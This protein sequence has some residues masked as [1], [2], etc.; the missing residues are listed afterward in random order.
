MLLSGAGEKAES[1]RSSV[2]REDYTLARLNPFQTSV[3][4]VSF[5]IANPT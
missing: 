4:Q 1:V 3:R 5:L 2:H